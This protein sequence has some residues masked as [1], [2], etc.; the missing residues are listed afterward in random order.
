M[1]AATAVLDIRVR[2][3][4]SIEPILFSTIIYLRVTAS[5]IAWPDRVASGCEIALNP[6]VK[7]RMGSLDGAST[8][9]RSELEIGTV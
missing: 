8:T 5:Q 6:R 4:F 3:I 7:G 1:I 9:D 2:R